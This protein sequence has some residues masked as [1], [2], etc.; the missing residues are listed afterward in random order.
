LSVMGFYQAPEYHK[1]FA[2]T[3]FGMN[4][5]PNLSEK[6]QIIEN[7]V[8]I[9]H[10]MG[11]DEPKVAVL[12]A[13][14]RVNPK[15]PECVDACELKKMN[16]RGELTGCTV[17]GPISFD[18]AMDKNAALEKNYKSPVAGDADLLVV[19]DITSGNILV[20]ALTLMADSPTAGLTLG[21]KVP[22]I[23]TSRS[24]PPKDKFYT[25]ALAA[26]SARALDNGER[27]I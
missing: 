19:P 11:I 17:E 14:E 7:A 16:I 18:L 4:I 26:C 3:D 22:I 21:A 23:M 1:M 8:R 13:V 24:A 10:A 12:A 5:R 20:K 25:I 9:F 6:K 27:D 2:V 15:M